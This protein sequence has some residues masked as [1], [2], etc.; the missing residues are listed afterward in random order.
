LWRLEYEPNRH[1][2]QP[3][4]EEYNRLNEDRRPRGLV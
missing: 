2:L 3:L 1:T 4:G